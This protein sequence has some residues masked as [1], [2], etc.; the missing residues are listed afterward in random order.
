M[1]KYT[2]EQNEQYY[3]VRLDSFK[4][5]HSKG[6]QYRSICPLHAGGDNP[7]AL[8]VNLDEG[9]F[10]CFTKGCKGGSIYTFEMMM[11]KIEGKL[12]NVDQVNESLAN[13]L[14]TPFTKR[15]YGEQIPKEHKPWNRKL[16]QGTYLYTDEQGKER[17]TVY[18]FVG[19]DGK[20]HVPCDRPCG[21]I[22]PQSCDKNC[23]NGRIWD[24]EGVPRIPYRISDVI[25]SL[26]V[27]VVE[28][29][30]NVED[31]NRAISDHLR[32]NGGFNFGGIVLD[33]IAVTT[34]QSGALGWKS[35]LGY[36]KYFFGRT[37]IKLGDNDAAGRIHDQMV[38]DDVS[39]YAKEYYKLDLP[40]GEGEDISDFLKDHSAGDLFDLLPNRVRHDCKEHK[41]VVI[42]P[43]SIEMKDFFV[44]PSKL[45]NADKRKRDWL[46][47]GL[48]ERG[49]KGLVV[50]RPKTGKSLLF[51]EIAVCL[52]SG[53]G[54]FGGRPY[55][56]PVKVAVVSREDGP[57]IVQDRL[58]QLAKGHGLDPKELDRNVLINTHEQAASFNIQKDDD[59]KKMI[60]WLRAG[61]VEF[62]VIDVL[63]RIHL[64]KE[65]S[66]DEMKIVM[67]SIEDIGKEAECQMCVIHHTR[68]D[69]GV[70]GATSIE[71]WADYI[72]KLESDSQDETIKTLKMRTKSSAPIPEIRVRYTQ[73]EDLTESRIRLL[74]PLE[75]V[76]PIKD[77]KSRASDG[78]YQ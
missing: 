35:D 10:V 28:G 61:K 69:G 49:T 23:D 29:E 67:K 39:R 34:N 21:C 38:Q 75:E 43:K 51:L 45:V 36:G 70:K 76:K 52:A 32:K 26:L 33:R 63:E 18:R 58:Y 77:Y 30:K 68:E 3:K 12:H 74:M 8:L 20:K 4:L 19:K 37:V 16:A 50:A 24:G 31:L 57:E 27:F 13:I 48:I 40:V 65:N 17:L 56:R 78:Y 72:F 44:V 62:C 73:S 64:A 1:N 22:D 7:E 66:N 60:D 59:R 71:G 5:H 25:Q 15:F 46:V 2:A 42:D 14:G 54:L 11:L 53:K 9:N 55:V 6:M 41:Q 47:E